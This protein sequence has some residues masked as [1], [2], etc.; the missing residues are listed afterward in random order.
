MM[1]TVTGITAIP[2]MMHR[3]HHLPAR[4]ALPMIMTTLII[5]TTHRLL[6]LVKLALITDPIDV[7]EAG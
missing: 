2:I 5:R 1:I 3:L 6:L 7:D 4:S